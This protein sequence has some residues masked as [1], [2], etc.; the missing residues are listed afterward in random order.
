M[1]TRKQAN[2]AKPQS[3]RRRD[4]LRALGVGAG[5]AVA[6]S[7]LIE[8]AAAQVSNDEKRKARYQPNSTDVQN[9]YRVNRYPT[10]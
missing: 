1:N 5:A 8:P 10:K 3:V 2:N 7:T 9:Y 4:V 6:S